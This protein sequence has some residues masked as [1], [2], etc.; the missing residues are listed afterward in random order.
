MTREFIP[1][2][3]T[4]FIIEKID[5][6]AQLEALLLLRNSPEEKW[7]VHVLSKRLYIDVGLSA[8]PNED[9]P[10]FILSDSSLMYSS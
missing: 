8:N 10:F 6:V 3:I 4:E 2:D 5:S 1:A 7:S 9:Q